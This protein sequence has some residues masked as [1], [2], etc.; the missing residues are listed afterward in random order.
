MQYVFAVSTA[1][2]I[3]KVIKR[4]PAVA[5][6]VFALVHVALW[7]IIP[8]ILQRSLQFDAIEGVAYGGSWQLGYWKHPP[9]PWLLMG[10]THCVFGSQ[11][12]AY[13]LLGQLAAIVAFWATWRLGREL[14]TPIEAFVAVVL[15]DGH[16][17][18]NF[19]TSAPNHHI[20]ELPFFALA[21]WSLYRAFV[22][23][24][25]RDW[26]LVGLWFALAF[27]TK[28]QTVVLLLPAFVFSIVNQQA[29]QCWRKRGPYV[30]ALVCAVLCAPQFLWMA[31]VDRWSAIKFPITKAVP[32]Q[33][34][35]DML[36]ALV[37]F[38]VNGVLYIVP[39]AALFSLCLLIRPVGRPKPTPPPVSNPFA[40]SYLAF[41]A[42]GPMATC[43]AVGLSSGRHLNAGWAELCSCFISLYLIARW[44]P[45]VN[46]SALRRLLFG[47]LGVTC[48][49]FAAKVATERFLVCQG[50][51]MESQFPAKQFS[52]MVTSAWHEEVGATPVP[53]V[54]G[55]FWSAGNVILFSREQS[56]FFD[57][58]DTAHS[59]LVDPADV[60]RRGAVILFEPRVCLNG[61]PTAE[62]NA[63]WLTKFP[64]AEPRPPF[65]V[66]VQTPGGEVTWAI[67]WALLK[68]ETSM[69]VGA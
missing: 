8:A 24:A 31:F 39:V 48:L 49:L 21:A 59:P 58:G 3:V 36:W 1:D 57:K 65:I 2:R 33:S 61:L 53:Y 28:Y 47:W 20:L 5:F 42:V 38:S 46:R 27:Y 69:D 45:V 29:R 32:T 13:F 54:V 56:Q 25:W 43:L 30:A 22:G 9:L 10:M 15:L 16:I 19:K 64:G 12:W 67:G 14:F 51:L 17:S 6:A 4:R 11:L 40:R 63:L 37:D 50:S 41:L 35:F 55:E 60:Q 66:R 23:N 68:P 26:L 44:R 18:Y 62:I 52:M 34:L 7:T